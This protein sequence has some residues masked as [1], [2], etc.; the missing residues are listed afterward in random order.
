MIP[1]S[2]TAAAA[3]SEVNEYGSQKERFDSDTNPSGS[4]FGFE[5]DLSCIP[6]FETFS[7]ERYHSQLLELQILSQQIPH[8]SI[9]VPSPLSENRFLN[10]AAGSVRN[11]TAV[12]GDVNA[13]LFIFAVV[14]PSERIGRGE[15]EKRRSET[16]AGRTG[17]LHQPQDL[18]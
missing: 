2:G 14:R 7:L 17:S 1:G 3:V 15:E 10:V 11:N 12:A 18:R 4:G 13:I 16:E 8:P 5:H 6:V 9:W